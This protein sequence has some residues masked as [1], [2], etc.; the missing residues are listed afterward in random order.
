MYIVQHIY[1]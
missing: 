1:L